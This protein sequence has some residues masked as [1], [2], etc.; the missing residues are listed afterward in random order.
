MRDIAGRVAVALPLLAGVLAAA[1]FG[2]WWLFAVAVLAAI[3]ALHELYSTIRPL[4]PLVLAGYAGVLVG[5]VAAELGGPGWFLAGLLS[6]FLFAFAL[7]GVA[8]TRQSGT[9]TIAT[10]VLGA[11]WIGAGIGHLILL[12]Q[13]D[14][15]EYLGRLAIFTVLLAVWAADTAAYFTGRLVGR[16]KLAAVMSPG[17]TWEGF[18]AGFAAA[19]LVAFFAL[20]QDRDDFLEIWQALVLGAVIAVAGTIGDLFESAVKRDMEVKDTGRLLGGHGGVL[21]RID[22]LLFASVAGYYTVVALH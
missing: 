14:G 3:L 6:T 12:R 20:Y 13:L 19:V 22:S 18:V 21:D 5:L 9:V 1:Y 10:T 8:E 11:F 15:D 16:H 17:K 7:Y 4:R 2:G